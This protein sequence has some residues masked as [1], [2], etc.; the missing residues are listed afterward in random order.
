MA[1]SY[2]FTE[3]PVQSI[4]PNQIKF[5]VLDTTVITDEIGKLCAMGAVRPCEHKHDEFISNISSRPK[6]SGGLHIIL[7]LKDL[8]RFFVYNHFKMEHLDHVTDLIMLNDYMA[9]IDLSDAYFSVKIHRIYTKFLRFI[10]LD[11]LYE[12]T[13]LSFG[14]AAAPRLFTKLTKLVMA[15]LHCRGIKVSIF[16]D[17]IIIVNS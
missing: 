10:W 15:Q 6:R 5:S 16:I 9:F 11:K 2:E 13:C 12:Y 4:T 3:T 7:N 1:I 14:Y 8:N 17:D